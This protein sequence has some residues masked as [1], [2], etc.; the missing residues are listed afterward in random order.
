MPH[1]S[2]SGLA[3]EPFALRERAFSDEIW[4]EDGAIEDVE[5]EGILTDARA[6]AAAA[7]AA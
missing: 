1:A 2:E 7:R 4:V 5:A 3:D 6:C